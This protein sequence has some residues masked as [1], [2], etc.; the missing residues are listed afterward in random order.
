MKLMRAAAGYSLLDH[1]DIRYKRITEQSFQ[2]LAQ[3]IQFQILC[4][5]P[6]QRWCFEG[7]YKR[8][9]ET[10]TGHEAQDVLQL[11]EMRPELTT[12]PRSVVEEEASYGWRQRSA[13]IVEVRCPAPA[14]KTVACLMTRSRRCTFTTFRKL[15][16]SFNNSLY[17]PVTSF[18]NMTVK[19]LWRNTKQIL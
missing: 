4:Y 8:W 3:R 9:H 13:R 15:S 6:K 12:W 16:S 14:I 2:L 17:G 5:Q 18:K 11:Q 7:P 19:M 1:E 10:M